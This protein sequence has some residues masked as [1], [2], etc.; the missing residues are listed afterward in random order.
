[1][2]PHACCAYVVTGELLEHG[3]RELHR[4]LALWKHCKAV[5]EWPGYTTEMLELKAPFFK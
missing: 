3:W 2:T 1:M 5:G 4:L